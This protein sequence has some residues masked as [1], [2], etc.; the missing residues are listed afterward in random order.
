L[1][2]LLTVLFA[3]LQVSPRVHLIASGHLPARSL[4]GIDDRATITARIKGGAAS[5][6]GFDAQT[7]AGDVALVR[8]T[9]GE[10]QRLLR[11]P[12]LLQVDERRVFTTQLDQAAAA[13]GA[14]AA[15]MES[16]L[17]GSGVL[18]GIVDTGADV[19]HADL[20]RAGGSTK[21]A[22][23]LDVTVASDMRHQ[24]LGFYGG[25]IWLRDE[26]DG[27]LALD[28]SFPSIDDN[29][30]GTHVAGIAA[31]TGLAT[32]NGLPAG[33]YVGIAP[34]ADLV[35]AK[36]S[37]GGGRFREGDLLS[38]C[39]FVIDRAR[40]LGQ[41]L[42]VNLSLGGTGG[43]HDGTTNTEQALA[44]LF[45]AD[46]PGRVLVVAAGNEGLTDRHAG[47]WALDGDV[48]IPL[49][50]AQPDTDGQVAIDLWTLGSP[51]ITVFTPSGKQVG[52][53]ASTHVDHGEGTE[54]TVAVDHTSLPRQSDGRQ[55]SAIVL[56]PA[57]GASLASGDWRIR[58]S[59]R[60]HRW[61]LWITEAAGAARFADHLD[62]DD[63]LGVLATTPSAVAVGSF[64]SRSRWTT[65]DGMSYDRMIEVGVPSLFSSAGPS[66]DGR[67]VPDLSAPGEFILSALSR[68]ALPDM[69]SSDFF[70][71]NGVTVTWADDGVHGV[72][73][74]TSQSAPMVTGAVALLLQHD[75]TLT[76]AQ[77]K[78]LL[79]GSARDL[80]AGWSPRSGFGALDVPALLALAR[81]RLGQTADPAL[82][83]VGVSRDQLPPGDDLTTIT[84]TPRDAG[85]LLLGPGHHVEITVSAGEPAAEV[86]DMGFGRYERPIRAHAAR[87]Q[88]GVVTAVVDGVTLAAHPRIY[89]VIGR[90]E[91][92]RPFHAGGGC[93]FS[94]A[95]SGVG[96]L[97]LATFL[98]MRR[99]YGCSTRPP[100]L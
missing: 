92:G 46:V 60:A 72:L 51:A 43:A 79:R 77:V 65:V 35:V 25:A 62:E 61:D 99:S 37:Y 17:D 47:G 70:A 15:R 27:V 44:A 6:P 94:G 82:S 18:V 85:G 84:V 86:A 88:V 28:G 42:V 45:P 8:V 14:P 41:P 36:A 4:A 16:G 26:I 39:R 71:G 5:L 95:P 30:H 67:F 69:P 98:W 90:D 54:G 52:P 63:R 7:L 19:T 75:P 38:S 68:N 29:G 49:H 21:V 96:L 73:R 10:L 81:G 74:G 40:D 87:G 89:Y 78:E 3:Q 66:A 91:I 64:V 58:L 50:L 22:A 55:P 12:G 83:S 97:V 13:V 53:V 56:M 59:G 93:S 11:V 32:G 34:G 2:A 33:R 23:L 20:R 48:D 31:S 24:D 100:R 80:G 1:L 57:S 9:S 76:A